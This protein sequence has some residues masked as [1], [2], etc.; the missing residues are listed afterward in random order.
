M[1][2]TVAVIGGGAAGL[3]AARHLADNDVAVTL[4]EQAKIL[5]GRARSEVLAGCVVDVGAQLFGSAFTS[6]FAFAE[7]MGAQELLV[8]SP[9]R[10][11]VLRDGTIHPIMY[12]SVSSMITSRALPGSLKFKLATRY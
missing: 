9:G 1:S 5:G 3:S 10:D 7:A 8:R 11:A 4:F 2:K 6:L 12:G